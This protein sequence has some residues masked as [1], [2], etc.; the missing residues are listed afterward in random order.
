MASRFLFLISLLL[1]GAPL[2]A[3]GEAPRLDAESLNTAVAVPPEACSAARGA[4]EQLTSRGA[5]VRSAPGEATLDRAA[6]LSWSG[7]Q[8]DALA[9][10]LA[11]EKACAAPEPPSETEI[12]IRDETGTI[13]WRQFVQVRPSVP[14][15]LDTTN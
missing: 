14:L 8:R 6:W 10:T 7:A 13:L 15:E 5:V 12:V 3:C 11:L 4:L 2:A 9:Q 1:A